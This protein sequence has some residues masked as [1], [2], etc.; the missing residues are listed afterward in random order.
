MKKLQFSWLVGLSLGCSASVLWCASPPKE[1]YLVKPSSQTVKQRQAVYAA[2]QSKEPQ[3]AQQLMDALAA[4]DPMTRTLAL[5]GLGKLKYAAAESQIAALLAKDPY[6]EVREAAATSLR[7]IER[8]TAVDALGKALSDEAVTVRLTALNGIAHY[9][10]A[11]V[12]PLVEALTKDKSLEVRRTAVYVLG[13]LDDPKAS[14]AIQSLLVDPDSGVRAGAAQA[15]GELRAA[16][17]K[18]ALLPLLK[19]PDKGVRAVTARSLEM[20][21]DNSGFELAKTLAQDPDHNIRLIAIDALGWS[22]NPAAEA[23]LQALLT[24]A[25][26]DSRPLIQEA[27]TRIQQSKKQ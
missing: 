19:D 5:Q 26:P 22:K 20:L 8:P 13:Q 23:E 9:R 12:R 27:L 25:P 15:L 14:P 17:A 7:E 1:A 10:D 2:G 3:A 24:Q 4:N 21:G 16:D 18:G 6:P 11:K